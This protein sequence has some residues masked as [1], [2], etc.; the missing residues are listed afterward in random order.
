MWVTM[1]LEL[2]YLLLVN[3]ALNLPLT[4]TLLNDIRPDKFAIHW[5]RAWS[6]YPFGPFFRVSTGATTRRW[7]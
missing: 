7:R 4:Q 6:W 3:A 5:Q 2:G 1:C